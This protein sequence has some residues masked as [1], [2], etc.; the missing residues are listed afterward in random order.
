MKGKSGERG[1]ETSEK[2]L[3]SWFRNETDQKQGMNKTIT[4]SKGPCKAGSLKSMFFKL[5]CW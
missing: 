2:G 1:S 4:D 5:V 3:K